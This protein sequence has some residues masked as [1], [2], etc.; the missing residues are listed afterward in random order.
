[1]TV[2]AKR[3]DG[4]SKEFESVSD[5]VRWA[6]SVGGLRDWMQQGDWIEHYGIPGKCGTL[7]VFNEEGIET[8]AHIR[9][10]RA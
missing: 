3:F 10:H 7:V 2:Q 6:D 1:M 8:D 4:V 5:V 9:W